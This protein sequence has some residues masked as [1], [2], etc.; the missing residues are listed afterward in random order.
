M[1]CE[2]SSGGRSASAARCGKSIR[3]ARVAGFGWL[4]GGGDLSESVEDIE[5]AV[6]RRRST[7][8]VVMVERNERDMS[9]DVARRMTMARMR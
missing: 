4:A 1:F 2:S 8:G 9:R 3:L 6:R 7:R 5:C